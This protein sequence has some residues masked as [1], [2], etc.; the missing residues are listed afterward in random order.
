MFSKF[1][2]MRQN[3]IKELLADVKKNIDE[4]IDKQ[5]KSQKDPSVLKLNSVQIKNCLENLRSTLDYVAHD[6]IDYLQKEY[7]KD[8]IVKQS[9][10]RIYFPFGI[11][12]AAFDKSVEKYLLNL[13]MYRPK[14]Y[15][16]VKSVQPF[17]NGKNW[18][19]N[20]IEEVNKIK[21]HELTEQ[22][23][24]D[25]VKLKFGNNAIEIPNSFSANLNVSGCT[26]DGVEQNKPLIIE[27]GVVKSTPQNIPQEIKETTSYIFKQS[28]IFILNL[29]EESHNDILDFTTKLYSSLV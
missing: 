1:K 24:V 11:T 29:L 4:L 16:L 27:K 13:K 8:G 25:S 28:N 9:P 3:N 2:P 19:K 6:I 20:L 26:F 15:D 5:T 22:Q 18:L 17:V 12:T 21:H 23:R 7:V 14:I 10:G